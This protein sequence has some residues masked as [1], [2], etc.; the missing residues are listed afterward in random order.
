MSLAASYIRFV[1]RLSEFFGRISGIVVV[2]TVLV[3]IS[4][5]LLRYIGE[6]IGVKLVNNTFIELQWYLYTL[7]F[8]FGF[9]WILKNQIN[10]RVDFWFAN[11]SERR[12][13]WIDLVG[14]VTALIPFCL[15]GLYVT[16]QP[17]MRSLINWELSPDPNGLPRAPIKMMIIFAFG[18]LL[19]QAIAEL[20]KLIFI[21]TDNKHFIAD[22]LVDPEEPIRAE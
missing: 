22:T 16:W 11:Q 13:A 1:D 19:I 17:V 10:V 18:T 6:A 15:L 9:A 20:F 2:I 3:G 7:I 12:K 14:H 21:L 5:V 4:N 8:F